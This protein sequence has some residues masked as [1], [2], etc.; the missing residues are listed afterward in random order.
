MAEPSD[1]TFLQRA[2]DDEDRQVRL[3]YLKVSCLLVV[4]LTASGIPLDHIV[5]S[6]DAPHIFKIRLACIAIAILLFA[7]CYLASA[8]RFIRPLGL[9]WA[10]MTQASICTMIYVVDDGP[11]ST[12]YA[13]LNLVIL[14][15]S[16][17][18][19]WTFV[20]TLSICIATVVMFLLT[21]LVYQHTRRDIPFTDPKVYSSISFLFFT[22]AICATASYFTSRQRLETFRLRHELDI[23]NRELLELDKLKTNFFSNISHELRT[24]LTLMISPLD[25]MIRQDNLPENV[26]QQLSM[27]QQNSLRL[28]KL[29]ND[30]LELVRLEDARASGANGSGHGKFSK[31]IVDL[32]T[33]LPGLVD[34]VRHLAMKKGLKVYT[35]EGKPHLAIAADPTRLETVVLNL[36]MNAVKFTPSGGKITTHWKAEGT[37]AVIEI[38]DTGIGIA[39]KDLPLLFKRF[40]QVDSSTTRPHQGT[41]IGLALAKQLV[42]EHGGE[43][44]VRSAPGKGSTF[45]MRIPLA[46]PSTQD[47]PRP[48]GSG[49]TATNGVNGAQGHSA[50]LPPADAVEK[51]ELI[52][53]M[54]RRANR[55]LADDFHPIPTSVIGQGD[56]TVLVV[57]DEPAI[58][59]YVSE[60]LARDYR[61]IQAATGTK[62]LEA[63]RQ[64]RPDLV[65][66]DLM[67]PEMDGL[68]VCGHIKRD[69]ATKDIR[70]ILLTARSD[71]K[72][73]LDALD[74]GAD[75]FLLKPFSTRELKTRVANLIRSAKLEGEVRQRNIALNEALKKL[76]ETQAQLIQSEK[77]NALG[78]LAGGLLH[79]INNPLNIGMT[80]AEVG[81]QFVPE[82]DEMLL[83]AMKTIKDS[84]VRIRDI[85]VELRQFATPKS[86]DALD[87][88]SVADAV[89]IALRFTSKEVAGIK[90][91][92]EGLNA[93]VRASKTLTT[94]VLVNLISN[95]A[96]ALH[97]LAGREKCIKLSAAKKGA[98]VHISVWDNGSGMTPEVLKQIFDPFFTTREPGQ[99]TGL[100]LSVCHTI[101]KKHNGEISARSEAGQWSE[102]AFDLPTAE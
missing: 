101:V 25:E 22:S 68:T 65:V 41:G 30:L 24:P 71:E 4:G 11:Q 33:F 89:D 51:D 96:K 70:V 80:A 62:G 93:R 77:M 88:F 55:V 36:L 75:D 28:L 73:R 56:T 40:S 53:D 44:D 13:G 49:F 2:Y 76:Q 64:H 10:L 95:A 86:A 5:Y 32:S 6:G 45:F 27:V 19:P 31:E 42:I 34:S 15:I 91:E 21:C 102:L 46:E 9:T 83:D 78:A 26:R 60:F 38:E 52:A 79:E 72:A 48:Q 69:A 50:D 57:D 3:R 35:D 90:I 98:R 100:G 58:R 23:R 29:I 66:L 43:L 16:I 7:L 12:Y 14:G 54:R 92:R 85:I 47:E 87:E 74:K 67:L 63:A 94:Q 18:L 20:E 61:V 1:P 81:S 99:G 39:E 8:V 84:M 59:K 37:N 17:F 82:N 97:P